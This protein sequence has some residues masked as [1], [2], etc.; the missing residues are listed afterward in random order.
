MAKRHTI[1]VGDRNEWAVANVANIVMP[2]VISLTKTVEQLGIV[3][4][5]LGIPLEVPHFEKIKELSHRQLQHEEATQILEAHDRPVNVWSTLARGTPHGAEHLLE[6]LWQREFE[7]QGEVKGTEGDDP[8][9]K[10]IRIHQRLVV[11][12]RLQ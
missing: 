6:K 8:S 1:A 3:D 9:I 11:L 10:I 5:N 2:S 7:A 12:P 4:T